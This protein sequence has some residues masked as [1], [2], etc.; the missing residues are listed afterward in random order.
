M[1][2]V[3]KNSSVFPVW[4]ILIPLPDKNS[5]WKSHFYLLLLWAGPEATGLEHSL[6]LQ[7]LAQFFS[8]LHI[9]FRE[10]DSTRKSH[11]IPQRCPQLSWGSSCAAVGYMEHDWRNKGMLHPSFPILCWPRHKTPEVSEQGMIATSLRSLRACYSSLFL[12]DID[13]NSQPKAALTLSNGAG[14]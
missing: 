3:F 12:P 1:W 2:F 5:G 8:R 10:G 6:N 14:T 11:R 13:G 9:H 7:Y 4:H